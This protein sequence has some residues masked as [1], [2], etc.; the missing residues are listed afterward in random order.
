FL[1]RNDTADERADRDGASRDELNGFFPRSSRVE[2]AAMELQL[3]WENRIQR[4]GYGLRVD[5]NDGNASPNANHVGDQT[6]GVGTA[7][8]LEGDI[9]AAPISPPLYGTDRVRSRP[10]P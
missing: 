4:E 1:E 3:A 2:T 10:N 6:G 9:G 5:T 8:D 7:A